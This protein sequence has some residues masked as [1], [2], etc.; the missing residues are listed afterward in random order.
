MRRKTYRSKIGTVIRRLW[1]ADAEQFFASQGLLFNLTD[2]EPKPKGYTVTVNKRTLTYRAKH[3][4]NGF[5]ATSIIRVDK[6]F[7]PL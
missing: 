2:N 1:D 4:V 5:E 6:R 7:P 3:V